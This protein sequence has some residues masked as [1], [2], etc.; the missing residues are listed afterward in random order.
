MNQEI[1]KSA[2]N[3]KNGKTY[4]DKELSNLISVLILSLSSANEV[5]NAIESVVSDRYRYELDEINKAKTEFINLMKGE[6][7][8]KSPLDL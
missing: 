4:S 3:I 5:D 1:I 8:R 2:L 7:P 6:K